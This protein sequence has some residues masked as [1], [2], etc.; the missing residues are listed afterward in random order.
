MKNA[1]LLQSWYSKITDNWYSWLKLELQKKGYKTNFIDIPEMRNDVPNMAKIIEFIKSFNVV[2]QDTTIVGHSL[3]CLLA[4]RLGEE[5]SF[6]K[7]ILVSGWDFDELTEGHALFWKNK[8]NHEKIKNHVKKIYVVHSDT[9]PYITA[10]T[11]K[12]MSKRLGAK[13]ILVNKGGH[14]TSK[15]GFIKLPQLI[16]II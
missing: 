13:F 7:M 8:I 1:L 9:D 2:D 6:Y 12:D 4:M 5:F 11:A 3:G 15:D 10:C 14:L 16:K